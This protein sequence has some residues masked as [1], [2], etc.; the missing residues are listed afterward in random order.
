MR[1]RYVL[2]NKRRFAATLAVFTILAVFTA[3][4]VDADAASG[5][6]DIYDIVRV[7]KGDTLWEIAEEHYPDSD[8]RIYIYKIKKMNNLTG[9][10]IFAG[11]ELM[12]PQ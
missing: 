2:K 11:Q 7:E 12:L 3:L 10:V 1:R 4:M 9:N 6:K 5:E 8:P